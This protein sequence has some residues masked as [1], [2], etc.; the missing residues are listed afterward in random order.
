MNL[1]AR[2]VPHITGITVP[3]KATKLRAIANPSGRKASLYT[4]LGV[5]FSFRAA[6]IFTVQFMQ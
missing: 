1:C 6:S 2:L 5:K 4:V 3:L